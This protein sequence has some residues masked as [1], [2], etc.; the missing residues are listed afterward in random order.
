VQKIF[1][2]QGN[3]TNPNPVKLHP[4]NLFVIQVCRKNAGF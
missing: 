4:K 1:R 3:I 2:F